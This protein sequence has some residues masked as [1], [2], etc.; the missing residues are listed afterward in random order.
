MQFGVFERLT[1]HRKR[2]AFAGADRLERREVGRVDGEDVAFLGFVAPDLE[3]RE[4]GVGTGNAAQVDAGTASAVLDQLGQG[5]RESAG[6]DVVNEADRV[7][8]AE[9]PAAVDH[10]LAAVFHLGVVALHRREIEV[11]IARPRRH[12]RRG[13]AAE[14]DQH[15]RSAEHHQQRAR[16]HVALQDVRLADV[17]EATGDHDRLVVTPHPLAIGLFQRAEVAADGRAAELVVEGGRADRTVEHDLQRR[18]NSFGLAVAVLPRLLEPGHTQ[19][20]DAEA[21]EA[22]LGARAAANRTFVANLAA[23]ASGR[24]GVRRDRRRVVVRLDL[25]DDV[26]GLIVEGEAAGGRVGEEALGLRAANDGRVVRIGTEDVGV[27]G[28]LVSVADHAEEALRLL[29]TIDGPGGVEDL[30]AAVLAVRLRE[31]HQ[32]DVGRV[33]AEAGEGGAEVVDLV[34]RE[35]ES[36]RAVG[37]LERCAPAAEDVHGDQRPR[38]T[39]LEQPRRIVEPAEHALH[40]AVVQFGGHCGALTRRDAGRYVDV[41]RDAALDPPHSGESGVADDIGGLAGPGGEGAW[42]WHDQE[43]FAVFVGCRASGSVLEQ[44]FENGQRLGI[45]WCLDVDEVHEPGPE[46]ANAGGF[47]AEASEQTVKTEG[48]KGRSSGQCQHAGVSQQGPA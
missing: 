5:I 9:L 44:P 33:A 25:H 24:A 27:G 23:R 21:D 18:D 32:L 4:R 42:A 1:N 45:E 37:L 36:A 41:I 46:A 2:A 29:G 47:A 40:H 43:Q 28:L 39:L 6:T 20:R 48:R 8:V 30:V 10:L 38:R 16:R 17:A 19:V 11:G 13:A 22:G 3:R 7:T 26:H 15:R 31:H 34:R 35:G 14:P 12:R